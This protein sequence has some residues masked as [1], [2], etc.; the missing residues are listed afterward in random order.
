MTYNTARLVL[1]EDEL[2]KLRDKV[3]VPGIP[4]EAFLTTQ[5]RTVL[6]YLVKPVTDQIAHAMRER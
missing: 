4:V 1:D 5:E 2:A 3:L 6:S